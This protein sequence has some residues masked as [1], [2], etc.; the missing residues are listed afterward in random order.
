M[1]R[2]NK[3]GLLLKSFVILTAVVMLNRIILPTST[4]EKEKC[5]LVGIIDGDTILVMYGGEKAKVRLIGIDAPE[6][7]HSDESKNNEYGRLAS[8]YTKEQLKDTEYVYL[9]FDISKYDSYGRLLAYVYFEEDISDFTES[10]NHTLASD[11]YAVNKAYAPN[12][13]YAAELSDAC[14]DAMN[15]KNGLWLYDGFKKLWE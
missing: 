9:E 10:L 15:N 13:R 8:D 4:S 5:E 3:K 11:G 1:L 2:K 14:Q 7:V 6:S 12:T